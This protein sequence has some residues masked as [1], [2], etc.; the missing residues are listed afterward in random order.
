MI[1]A[2]DNSTAV[3]KL[4]DLSRQPEQ[5]GTRLPIDQYGYDIQRKILKKNKIKRIL[6]NKKL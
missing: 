5:L 2:F 1:N 4:V 6:L 3:G